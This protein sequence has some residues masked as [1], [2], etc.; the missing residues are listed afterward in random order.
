MESLDL[1]SISIDQLDQIPDLAMLKRWTLGC[2][3]CDLRQSATQPVHS[4]GPLDSP[5]MFVGM[6]P[7]FCEDGSL[8]PFA[9]RSELLDSRC[10]SCA[11]FETCYEWQTGQGT[12]LRPRVE[13]CIGWTERA[14]DIESLPTEV[15][16]GRFK[17][18]GVRSAGQIFDDLLEALGIVRERCFFTN[19]ALCKSPAGAAPKPQ[20]Y[21]RCSSIRLRTQRL[22]QPKLIVTLGNDATQQYS[23]KKLPMRSMHGVPF[24]YQDGEFLKAPV[25]PTYHPSSILRKMLDST[26]K[27]DLRE[28]E[29]VKT[30]I[31]EEKWAMYQDLTTAFNLLEPAVLAT[32]V[33]DTTKLVDG[34]LPVKT[35]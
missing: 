29:D 14:N 20:N 8:H 2:T 16:A 21:I 35:R 12:A 28:I 11:N 22:L 13:R 6:N 27:T 23:G 32:L 7:G 34:K 9:G 24:Q 33:K 3:A 17:V 30:A 25:V 26:R 19:S 15:L 4:D 31:R 5:V 18:G 10:T 1:T